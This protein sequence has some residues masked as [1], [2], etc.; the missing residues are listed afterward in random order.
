MNYIPIN[1]GKDHIN[2]YTK[3]STE[4]GRLLTNL[5]DVPVKVGD[6]NF[7][8]LEGLWY[9]TLLSLTDSL[10]KV[11]LKILMNENGFKVKSHSREVISSHNL[12][13]E[14]DKIRDTEEFRTSIKNFITIK[15]ISND[16]LMKMLKESELPLTHYYYYGKLENPKVHYL[17]EYQWMTDHI[18]E[19]R[20]KLQGR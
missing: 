8:T 14:V 7:R 1:D 20:N 13:N 11:N 10:D 19:L 9:F 17:N 18:V 3:G 15:I 12:I 5:S 4:L 2:I 16:K 6:L